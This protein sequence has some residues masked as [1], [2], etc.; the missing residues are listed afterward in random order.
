[1]THL[2]DLDGQQVRFT[3]DIRSKI[4]PRAPA[5]AKVGDYGRIVSG[6]GKL[7][8]RYPVTVYRTGETVFAPH[9]SF[10]LI[11]LTTGEQPHINA[12]SSE[13][14]I[15]AAHRRLDELETRLASKKP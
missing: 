5:A 7:E 9:D 4:V 11:D 1:M 15:E 13:L 12:E 2:I 6:F 3:R 8:G 14:E 10:E